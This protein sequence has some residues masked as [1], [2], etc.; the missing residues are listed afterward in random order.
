MHHWKSNPIRVK[1]LRKEKFLFVNIKF[2]AHNWLTILYLR[3]ETSTGIAKP[4]IL[5]NFKYPVFSNVYGISH[6][7]GTRHTL[8]MIT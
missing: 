6:P 3:D 4:H 1:K 8:K 2:C 7:A 5:E